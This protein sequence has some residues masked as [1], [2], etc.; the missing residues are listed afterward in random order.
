MY[1][2]HRF[3]YDITCHTVSDDHRY[4]HMGLGTRLVHVRGGTNSLA[5]AQLYTCM[6]TLKSASAQQKNASNHLLIS[7]RILNQL[8]NQGMISQ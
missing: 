8:L 3:Q 1:E 4:V 6:Y 7:Q 2:R 5:S